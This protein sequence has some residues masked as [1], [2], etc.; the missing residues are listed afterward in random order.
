MARAGAPRIWPARGNPFHT[1][2][3]RANSSINRP[4]S[5]GAVRQLGGARGIFAGGQ[6][7][8]RSESYARHGT[9]RVAEHRRRQIRYGAQAQPLQ[10]ARVVPALRRAFGWRKVDRKMRFVKPRSH[11][12]AEPESD[13]ICSIVGWMPLYGFGFLCRA[14]HVP[15]YSALPALLSSKSATTALTCL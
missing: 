10:P 15:F 12:S 1:V 3:P 4:A 13:G 2:Q 8:N 7:R 14:G 9:K 11:R 6:K 5:A